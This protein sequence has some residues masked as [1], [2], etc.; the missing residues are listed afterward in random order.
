MEDGISE[1]GYGRSDIG[2]GIWEMGDGRWDGLAVGG[3]R[4]AVGGWACG[5]E[6]GWSVVKTRG[7]SGGGLYWL[8]VYGDGTRP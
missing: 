7:W 5:C 1:M 3:W 2:D 8:V 4:L 6:S